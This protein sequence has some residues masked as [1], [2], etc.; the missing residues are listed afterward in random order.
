[1]P[2]V[3]RTMTVEFMRDTSR[4]VIPLHQPLPIKDRQRVLTAGCSVEDLDNVVAL[5][6]VRYAEQIPDLIPGLPE[7]LPVYSYE[8]GRSA[9]TL[10]RIYQGNPILVR[11]LTDADYARWIVSIANNLANNIGETHNA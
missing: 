2:I 1:M 3:K 7:Y 8:W 11:L 9:F 4:E 5:A 6:P 10:S